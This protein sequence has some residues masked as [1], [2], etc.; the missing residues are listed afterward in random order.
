LACF[1]ILR[2]VDYLCNPRNIIIEAECPIDGRYIAVKLVVDGKSAYS[3]YYTT[4]N[5]FPTKQ[6]EYDIFIKIFCKKFLDFS[7]ND[8]YHF[9]DEYMPALTAHR[10]LKKVLTR[11]GRTVWSRP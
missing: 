6:E 7:E 8:L 2:K 5:S 9:A 10:N 1:K 11:I 3:S 4:P